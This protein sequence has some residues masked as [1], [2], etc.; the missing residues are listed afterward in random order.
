ML[1]FVCRHSSKPMLAVVYLV[2]AIL[3][4]SII[5]NKGMTESNEFEYRISL[6]SLLFCCKAVNF[7]FNSFAVFTENKPLTFSKCLVEVIRLKSS[8]LPSVL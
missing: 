5:L 7:S 1:R 3:S 4:M 8:K 6:K 2:V